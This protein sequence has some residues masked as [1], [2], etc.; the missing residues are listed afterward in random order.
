MQKYN[1]NIKELE[2]EISKLRLE[3]ESSKI[4]ALRRGINWSYGS[5]PTDSKSTPAL[6]G[7][8]V[9]NVLKRLPVFQDISRAGKVKQEREC[10]MCMTED[11]SVIFLPCAHQVLCENC[12]VLHEKQGMNDC[13]SCRTPIQMRFAARF[14][15]K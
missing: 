6:Q 1:N 4:A 14:T 3:S 8:P 15:K 12:N 2:A 10:V 7:Y 5:V 13:P 9:P 11:I